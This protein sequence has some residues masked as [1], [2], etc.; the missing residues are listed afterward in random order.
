VAPF[1]VFELPTIWSAGLIA[2]ALLIPLPRLA[3]RKTIEGE[4]H[5][6]ALRNV[7]KRKVENQ[8]GIRMGG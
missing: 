1:A 8:H 2:F 4:R 5:Y 7:G 3:F 6:R